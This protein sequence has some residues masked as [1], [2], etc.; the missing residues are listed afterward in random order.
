VTFDSLVGIVPVAEEAGA[1]VS[2]VC[3]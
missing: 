2:V 3:G 1:T